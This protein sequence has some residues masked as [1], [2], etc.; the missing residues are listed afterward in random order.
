MRL[1]CKLNPAHLLHAVYLSRKARPSIIERNQMASPGDEALP[2]HIRRVAEFF[3][4]LQNTL[5]GLR[6][7]S[8]STMDRARNRVS[9]H[10]DRPG[11]LFNVHNDCP[12][13]ILISSLWTVNGMAVLNVYCRV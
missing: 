5:T 9:R 6:A 1:Q 12:K 11:D 4:L 3:Y 7:Q 2:I 13:F 8:T 10:T